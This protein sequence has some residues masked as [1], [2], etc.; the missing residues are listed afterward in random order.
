MIR[1]SIILSFFV[2]ITIH[3]Q[4]FAQERLRPGVI[5]YP[6]DSISAPSYGVV[7]VIPEG[8]A[9]V[10]PQD[11]EMFLLMSRDN[12]QSSIYAFG[13]DDTREA[14]KTRW[15][16]GPGLEVENNIKLVRSS[17]VF[18][19]GDVIAAELKVENSTNKAIGYMEA[20]C[21]EYEKCLVLLLIVPEQFYEESKKGLIVLF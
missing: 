19:R 1:K 7:S 12:P 11:T 16:T 6:G 14:I 4:P 10:L 9:G 20:K 2:T 3:L 5:Y 17:D 21:S 18:E 15:E 13:F 8:W